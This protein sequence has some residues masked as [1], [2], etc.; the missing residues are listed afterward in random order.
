MVRVVVHCFIWCRQGSLIDVP[1]LYFGEW[2]LIPFNTPPP[3][4]GHAPQALRTA[5]GPTAAATVALTVRAAPSSP[6]MHAH[7]HILEGL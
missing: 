2:Y 6:C 1:S 5:P 4:Q 7:K 3:P